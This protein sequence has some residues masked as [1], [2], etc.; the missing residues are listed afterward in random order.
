MNKGT[1]FGQKYYIE[2][3]SIIMIPYT[4]TLAVKDPRVQHF[5]SANPQVHDRYRLP[6]LFHGRNPLAIDHL[7]NHDLN[8]LTRQHLL[9]LIRSKDARS[10]SCR[11]QSLDMAQHKDIRRLP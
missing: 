9:R 5:M 10:H 8:I 1:A 3:V 6:S 7:I 2:I 11:D 4:S